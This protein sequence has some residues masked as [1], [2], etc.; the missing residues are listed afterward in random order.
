MQMEFTRKG[1]LHTLM[2]GRGWR[3]SGVLVKSS[4][5][6]ATLSELRFGESPPLLINDSGPARDYA[7]GHAM[8]G[9]R[10]YPVADGSAPL[11]CRCSD[12]KATVIGV[13]E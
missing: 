5:P 1:T 13:F 3:L 7:P 2:P 12:K 6:D 9:L 8:M 11:T 10:A 4:D